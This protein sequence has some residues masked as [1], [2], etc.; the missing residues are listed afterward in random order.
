MTDVEM[1]LQLALLRAELLERGL[2]PIAVRGLL[3][4]P[5]VTERLTDGS[6]NPTV[7]ISALASD[8]ARDVPRSMYKD[9]ESSEDW[10]ARRFGD[11]TAQ[12]LSRYVSPSKLKG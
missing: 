8:V 2:H 12:Y 1:K 6:G 7:E 5:A 9:A 10:A 3:A 11:S 4:D